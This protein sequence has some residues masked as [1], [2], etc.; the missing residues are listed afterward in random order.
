MIFNFWYAA[1]KGTIALISYYL[2]RWLT[3]KE[4]GLLIITSKPFYTE[5]GN[6]I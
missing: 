2:Q 6:G 4:D 5:D 3:L 1:F